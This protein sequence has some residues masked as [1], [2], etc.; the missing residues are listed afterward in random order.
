MTIWDLITPLHP[1]SLIYGEALMKFQAIPLIA[2]EPLFRTYHYEWQYFLMKRLGETEE[3]LKNNYLG[4]IYQSAWESKMHL[5]IPQKTLPSRVLR[6]IKRFAR[7]LQ[8][9]I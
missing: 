4:V 2:I 6:E 9:Y 8:N 5:G 7:Y 3:K 1:E